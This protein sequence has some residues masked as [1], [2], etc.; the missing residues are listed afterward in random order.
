MGART[1]REY[2]AI[3]QLLFRVDSD[4]LSTLE[5]TRLSQVFG[6][7]HLSQFVAELTLASKQNRLAPADP[8]VVT[9]ESSF[10]GPGMSKKQK[11]KR[12]GME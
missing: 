10:A 6:T 5:A 1:P 3:D 8:Q 9:L 2:S 4:V 7:H 12:Q 11:K